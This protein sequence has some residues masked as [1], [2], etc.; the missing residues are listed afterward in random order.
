M[1]KDDV[2]SRLQRIESK[3][4]NIQEDLKEMLVVLTKNTADVEY[5]IRRS[6]K[7]DEQVEI[8]KTR[9]EIS[10]ETDKKITW[11]FRVIIALAAIATFL[12]EMGLI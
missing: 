7:T 3:Q 6:D 4:D 10:E 11:T 2:V 1:N 12:K 5:H 9:L 8:L